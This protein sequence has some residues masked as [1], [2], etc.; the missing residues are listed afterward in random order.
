[1]SVDPSTSTGVSSELNKESIRGRVTEII[2]RGFSSPEI[3][4]IEALPA[5]GKSYDVLQWAAE[6]GNQLTVFGPHHDLLDECEGWC[7]A[8]D[9]DLS[10]TRLPSFHRDCA[11]V[12]LDNKGR[13]ADELTGKLLARYRQGLKDEKIH[14]EASRL[15]GEDLPC[16]HHGQ[17]PFIEKLSIE[18]EDYDVLLGHYLHA[19]QD[20]WTDNRY[21]AID[22]FPGDAFVQEYTGKVAPAIT[23]YLRKEDQLPFHDYADLLERG[24]DFP[25]EVEVWKDDLWQ[26]YD[27]SHATPKPTLSPL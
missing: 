1:M 18:V 14:K 20:D 12:S 24:S 15:F 17:C 6:T 8:D 25:M 22:E 27:S 9:L 23:A 5:S 21:V 16:Q 3:T 19:Y 10:V 13:P 4:L 7:K 11:S 26:P 2:R